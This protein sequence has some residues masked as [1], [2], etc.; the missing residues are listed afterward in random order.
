MR[1]STML[2]RSTPFTFTRIICCICVDPFIACAGAFRRKVRCLAR[3]NATGATLRETHVHG[4]RVQRMQRVRGKRDVLS[5][6]D[7]TAFPVEIRCA[8]TPCMA[9]G[10]VTGDR[11]DV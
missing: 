7:V 9:Y 1:G 5:W 6:C 8:D 11:P 2:C 10:A 3:S 4:V